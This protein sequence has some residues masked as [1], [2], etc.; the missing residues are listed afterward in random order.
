M[1]LFSA[2]LNLFRLFRILL[3][4]LRHGALFPLEARSPAWRIWLKRRT[5]PAYA[6]L[7]PGQRLVA[8]LQALGPTY[9]KFGQALSTRPDLVGEEVAAD[10]SEL[11]DRL[12][13]FAFA[14]VRAIIEGELDRPLEELYS[15]FDETPVAAA[16]IAQVHFAV[17]AEGE[18][19]A[20]K[21]LR[22]GVEAVFAGD[23]ELFGWMSRVVERVMPSARRLRL[24]EAVDTFADTVVQEMDLR[25]EAAAAA[26]MADNFT[27]DDDLIIPAIDWQRTA[28]RVMT[29]ERVSGI[30]I[31]EI[32]AL[33]AA[34]HEPLEVV[35]K[36]AAT[37]FN[38]V[39]RDGFFHADLHPGNLFVGAG[40]ELVAV[41]FGI[42]GRVDLATRKILAEMLVGFLNGNY[43]RVAEVHFEAGWV[44]AEKS[45]DMFTQACRSIAEPILGRPANE[46]SIARLLGQLFEVTETFAMEAQPQLLLLQKSMLVAEG[47]GRRLAPEVNMW[48]LAR[49]LIES[50]MIDTIGP[51]ARVKD[52]IGS[53]FA[54]LESLPRLMAHAEETVAALRKGGLKLHGDSVK[55]ISR[56]GVFPGWLPW[57]LVIVLLILLLRR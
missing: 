21:V 24:P 39:F 14:E 15:S 26:E 40:G 13:P 20:V 45:V 43:R 7:R 44:P 46:I 2:P 48:E 25:F 49:P 28:R 34:G 52:N 42:T 36:A 54:T 3:V 38:M 32:T 10:L 19:V 5:D 37:F 4:F 11:H 22:P 30:S 17:T 31:D 56:R 51:A 47:I 27:G 12:P 16:S 8:A 55:V 1:Y 35:R 53:L 9:I 6:A 29:L 23:I 41:D 57:A 18:P 33:Q 50:W